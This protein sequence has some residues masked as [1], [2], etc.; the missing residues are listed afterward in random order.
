MIFLVTFPLLST[1]MD[2][3]TSP[4]SNDVRLEIK[5]R[6]IES[7]VAF[8][9]SSFTFLLSKIKFVVPVLHFIDD[10]SVFGETHIRKVLRTAFQITDKQQNMSRCDWSLTFYPEVRIHSLLLLLPT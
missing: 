4:P 7:F 3:L 9:M 5:L 6:T 8:F 1:R 10:L 2:L